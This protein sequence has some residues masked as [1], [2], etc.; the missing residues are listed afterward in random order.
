M[1]FTCARVWAVV[2]LKVEDYYHQKKRWRLRL[3][4]KSGKVNEMPCHHQREAYIDTYISAA[5]IEIDRKE[6]LFR[7]AIGRTGVLSSRA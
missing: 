7:A 2:N 3:R 5:G 4:E 6:P 1:A